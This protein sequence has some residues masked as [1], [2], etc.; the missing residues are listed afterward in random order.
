M[1]V[2]KKLMENTFPNPFG[3]FGVLWRPFLILQAVRHCRRWASA[4]GAV[5]QVFYCSNYFVLRAKWGSHQQELELIGLEILVTYKCY[6][7][8][9]RGKELSQQCLKYY[10]ADKKKGWF[11]SLWQDSHSHNWLTHIRNYRVSPKTVP[12]FVYWV[13]FWGPRRSIL[14]IFQ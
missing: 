10:C 9:S 5:S 11:L 4:S 3:H 12:T 7:V 6:E 8:W 2:P 1:G 14:K 13:S